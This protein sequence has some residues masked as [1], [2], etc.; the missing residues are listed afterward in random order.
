[1]PAEPAEPGRGEAQRLEH[2]AAGH[3]VVEPGALAQ[4]AVDFLE[5]VATLH[6]D[7]PYA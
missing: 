7:P 2:R 3:R 5:S 1:M 4:L 6:G